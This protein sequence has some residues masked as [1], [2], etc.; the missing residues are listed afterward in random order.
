MGRHIRT[1]KAH[2]I[3]RPVIMDATVEQPGAYRFVYVLPLGAF[4]IFV[5]DT[6]Y[7]DVSRL[8]RSALSSR[9]DGYC[10]LHGWQEAESSATRPACCQW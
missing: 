4:E 9:I 10:A 6:Y 5:E 2:G 3:E 1:A 8:D 7:A